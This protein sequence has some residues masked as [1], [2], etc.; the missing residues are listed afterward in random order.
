MCGLQERI[1]KRRRELNEHNIIYPPFARTW[2]FK[3]E[4]RFAK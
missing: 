2:K 3:P 4:A 1:S